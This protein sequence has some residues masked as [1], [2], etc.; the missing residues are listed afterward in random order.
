VYQ[1][2]RPILFRLDPELA[3]HYTLLLMRLMGASQTL[4]GILTW[5][6]QAPRKPVNIFGLTF[7]NAV[8]IAAGYDKDAVAWQGL[9]CLGFGHVEVGTVTPLPQS[10]NPKPRV[11]RLIEDR[12]LINR[13]GFP[14]KGMD[15]VNNRLAGSKRPQGLILGVNLGVNK[16]TP[17]SEAALDYQQLIYTF[18]PHA[19]Y[20]VINISSPNTVGLRRL[21]ARELMD[22]LCSKLNQ[23]RVDQQSM[24]NRPIPLCVKLAPDLTDTELD[25][26]LEVI[27]K[28][29]IDGVIATNTTMTRP[30]LKSM[31]A[32]EIG[33]LSGVPL[34]RLSTEMV[35]KIY[36]RTQGQLPIIGVGGVMTVD[37]VKEKLDA[38]AAL[39]QIYTGL[40]YEGP[41]L[42]QRI[43]RGLSRL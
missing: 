42:G 25:D 34:R 26:A 18:A 21:Q 5:L 22:K 14:G 40:I 17:I 43:N 7:P 32:R 4:S 41:G 19:D 23:V 1:I 11:F 31:N 24:L 20:L 38:G 27:Q 28:R 30:G 3:H 6:Y 10:G 29:A 37:D 12:A 16:S 9:S 15:Y 36:Q 33:G 39:V 2:F 35:R 8:G 13:M